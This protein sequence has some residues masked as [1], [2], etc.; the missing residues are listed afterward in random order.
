MINVGT[1]PFP[2]MLYSYIRSAMRLR[3]FYKVRRKIITIVNLSRIILFVYVRNCQIVYMK[4][5]I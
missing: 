1:I 2:V 3:N 5:I 4:Y